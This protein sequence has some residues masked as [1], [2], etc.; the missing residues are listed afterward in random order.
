MPVRFVVDENLRGELWNGIQAHNALAAHPI[1]AVRVGD[2]ID[3]PLRTKD[4][5]ILIWAE[6]EARVLITNDKRSMPGHLMDHLKAGGH[7]PGIFEIRAQSSV[8]EIVSLL[9][10]VAHASDPSEWAD[11]I[12]FIP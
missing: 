9:A 3:L 5:A 1:D 11:T 10:A 4:P 8:S 2:P 6:R 12:T 7:S